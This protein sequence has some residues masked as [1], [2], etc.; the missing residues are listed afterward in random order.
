MLSAR[1]IWLVV[2]PRICLAYFASNF[3][4]ATVTQDSDGSSEYGIFQINSRSWCADHRN[5]MS[6]NLCTMLCSD[7]L[8]PNIEDD[9]T[10]AKRI[11]KDPQG[12]GSWY[13]KL[14]PWL[15]GD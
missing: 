6:E 15:S 4:T 10:C 5:T 3:N 7:L 2:S 13:A 8:T 9:I 12:M 14:A 1:Q 11:V